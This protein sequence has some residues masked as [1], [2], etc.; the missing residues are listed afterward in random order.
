MSNSLARDQILGKTAARA[1]RGGRRSRQKGNRLERALVHFLQNH[2]FAAERV[3]LSGSAGGS[4]VGDLSLPLLGVDRIVEVKVRAAGFRQLYAWLNGR[5]LLIVRADRAEP[6][7][8]HPTQI[9]RRDRDRGGALEDSI[10]I[11]VVV[12]VL[13]ILIA[14]AVGSHNLSGAAMMRLDVKYIQDQITALLLAHPELVEDEVL[15]ADS[16]EGQT[17]TFEFLSR[18]VR[19]IGSTQAII[20]GTAEYI[21]ELQERKARLERREQALR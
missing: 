12:L 18:I 7:S 2:G 14:V 15:R 10:M 11:V 4:Y 1:G 16:I 20:S 5:D 17:G 8:R 19:L 6:L 3:P 13:I 21:G 9:R